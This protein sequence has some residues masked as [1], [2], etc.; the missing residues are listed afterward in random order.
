MVA[1]VGAH[2]ERATRSMSRRHGDTIDKG[3]PGIGWAPE[4]ATMRAFDAKGVC[5]DPFRRTF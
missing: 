5:T 2:Y 1:K 3:L 4:A